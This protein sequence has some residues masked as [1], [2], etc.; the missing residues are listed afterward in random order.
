VRVAATQLC[1]VAA[2]SRTA[3]AAVVATR[4]S[5]GTAELGQADATAELGQADATAELG[6]AD[7][8]AELELRGSGAGPG[9]LD[10]RDGVQR[11]CRGS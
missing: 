5:A 9:G 3:E 8:T 1:G 6:Q 4:D 7:A 10:N 11:Q 2:L